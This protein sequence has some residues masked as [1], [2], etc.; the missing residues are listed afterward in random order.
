MRFYRSNSLNDPGHEVSLDEIVS[1]FRKSVFAQDW[2]DHG[3]RLSRFI[4]NY[5]TS[6]LGGWDEEEESFIDLDDIVEA[7]F[8][9][10]KA[11]PRPPGL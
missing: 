10:E 3:G 5:L 6:R 1:G 8:L 11:T 9:A 4:L 2:R 7:V